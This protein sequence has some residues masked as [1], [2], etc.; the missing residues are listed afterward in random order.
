MVFG[1]VAL[2]DFLAGLSVEGLHREFGGEGIHSAALERG[3]R[4]RAVTASILLGAVIAAVAGL[5]GSQ[6]RGPQ[7]LAG[8]GI[9]GDEGLEHRAA[10]IPKFLGEA[11]ATGHGEGA[12]AR[13]AR[14]LPQNLGPTGRPG[15][16]DLLQGGPIVAGSAVLGPVRSVGDE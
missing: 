16:G 6:G 10:G 4:T 15:R 2:P 5:H 1:E 13:A 9:S 7:L 3:R 12:E 8:V 11:A 14:N